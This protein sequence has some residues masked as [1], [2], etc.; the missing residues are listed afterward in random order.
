MFHKVC[1]CNVGNSNSTDDCFIQSAIA[2]HE[3]C[4]LK[5]QNWRRDAKAIRVQSEELLSFTK[6]Q[7]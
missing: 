7:V 1:G 5:F 4:N 6:V 3:D 2:C